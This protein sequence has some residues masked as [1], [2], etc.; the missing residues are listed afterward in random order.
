MS[1]QNTTEADAVSELKPL[2]SVRPYYEQDGIAIYN[3]DCREVV[4][5]LKADIIITDPPYSLTENDWDDF[6]IP[7]MIELFRNF[8]TVVLTAS[9][10][11]SSKVV[12]ADLDRFRHEW[13]WRK[14]RGSNFANTVREPFKEHECVLVFSDGKWTYNPQKQRRTG[15]GLDRVKYD[16]NS[17][18]ETENYNKFDRP[19]DS[20]GKDLRVPSSVQ[21]FNTQTGLHP[22]QKPVDLF[23]YLILTYTNPGDLIL[24]PFMGSGTTLFAA[25]Q[26]GRR[27]IGIDEKTKYCETAKERLAQPTFFSNAD[28]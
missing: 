7:E 24:D 26:L 15:S 4:P 21:K 22:T 2:L 8:K 3:T 12:C 27:V 11:F 9:Q 16:F 17:V 1:N 6:S 23:K 19:S 25:Q 28:T 10:P 18:T 14:N 13:I 5:Y 20:K